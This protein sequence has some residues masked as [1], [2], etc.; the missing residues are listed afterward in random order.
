MDTFMDKIAQKFNAQEMIKA[1]AE[2]EEKELKRLKAQL[3]EYDSRIQEIG[4][5]NLKNLEIADQLQAMMDGN[6][7]KDAQTVE[8]VHKECVKVYRN[9]QAV[10]DQG[11]QNQNDVI[12]TQAER[13][14]TQNEQLIAEHAKIRKK[15]GTLKAFAIIT[16]LLTV[17]NIAFAVLQYLEIL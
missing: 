10:V 9:V 6:A 17:G 16:M 13:L 11:F 8:N 15:I 5:L 14:A 7:E 3:S 2:A 4:K 1:N 12:T